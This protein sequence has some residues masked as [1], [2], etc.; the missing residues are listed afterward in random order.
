MLFKLLSRKD[1]ESFSVISRYKLV[2]KSVIFEDYLGLGEARSYVNLFLLPL[3]SIVFERKFL[4]FSAISKE[5][6]VLVSS[7]SILKPDYD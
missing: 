7:R 5:W 2:V 4:L 1:T 3:E 6:S